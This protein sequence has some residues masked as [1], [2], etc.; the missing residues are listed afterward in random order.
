MKKPSHRV[1]DY[2]PRF[3]KPEEDQGEKR[4]KT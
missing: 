4:K 2:I 1:V 3:N